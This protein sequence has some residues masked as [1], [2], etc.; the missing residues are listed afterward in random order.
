M[1]LESGQYAEEC[2]LDLLQRHPGLVGFCVDGSGTEGVLQ[3]LRSM[4]VKMPLRTSIF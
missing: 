2:M 1:A 4:P 3:A